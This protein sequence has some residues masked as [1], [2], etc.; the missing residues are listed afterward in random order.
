MGQR[1][2]TC[3]CVFSPPPAII[4]KS[5]KES[6]SPDNIQGHCGAIRV[7]GAAGIP[8]TSDYWNMSFRVRSNDTIYEIMTIKY[9]GH[10]GIGTDNPNGRLTIKGGGINIIDD[11]TPGA[12]AITYYED[13]GTTQIGF[14]G[15]GSSGNKDMYLF[16]RADSQVRIGAGNA[17]RITVTTGGDVGIGTDTP[18]SKLD[19]NG[20]IRG[21]YNTNTTSYFGRTAIGYNGFSDYCAVSH[22]DRNNGSDYALLQSSS[23]MTFLNCNTSQSIRFRTGNGDK[24]CMLA[25]GKFGIGTTSPVA[26]LEVTGG[27]DVG[28][29]VNSGGA[30]IFGTELSYDYPG[31]QNDYFT[32]GGSIQGDSPYLTFGLYVQNTIRVQGIVVLSDRRIKSNVVDIHDTTALDQIRLL[33]PK[34]YDYVDKVKRGGASVIGFIAQDVKEVLPSSVSVANGEIPNIYE[35]ATISSSNTVTFTNFN[36]SDLDGLGKLIAYLAEDKREELTITEVVDEHTVRV[37]EDM[38]LKGNQNQK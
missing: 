35:T 19:V 8:G 26:K 30:Q 16:G 10:V 12:R 24:M 22:I 29:R 32:N 27:Y 14:V 3:F 4:S 38:S 34:Y 36:T 5:S 31:A 21:A 1:N 9:N 37:E 25:N 6:S 28:F 23:G 18:S 17:E 13:D 20:S 33:K 7:Y 2:W 15:Q 11:S